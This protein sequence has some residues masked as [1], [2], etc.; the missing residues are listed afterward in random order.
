MEA[1]FT[2]A[3]R[4]YPQ[5]VSV[6][7]G[8]DEQRSHRMIAGSDVIL[9]PSRFE[10]CGL[11]QLYGLLYGT[12][13]LVRRV[14]GLADSVVDCSLENMADKTATGFVFD[15]FDIESFNTAARR[16]FAL[17]DRPADWKMVQQTAMQQH[18]SWDV[19]AKAFVSLY[20]QLEA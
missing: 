1:A 15:N 10:P 20:M 8:Y 5:S 12:L 7:I 4:L 2:D 9:V 11:T 18:F 17:Y 14:G 16:V 6:H 19:A 13:P 3:A